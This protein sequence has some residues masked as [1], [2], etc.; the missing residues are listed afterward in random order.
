MAENVICPICKSEAEAINVGS[1]DGVGIRCKTHG[2]FEV[3]D[4][5][6]AMHKDTE[7]TR[8]EA[9]LG[10]AKEE[11]RLLRRLG[12]GLPPTIL[13]ECG[14]MRLL[15]LNGDFAGV[16][17][18]PASRRQIN[19]SLEARPFCRGYPPR[20]GSGAGHQ[21]RPRDEL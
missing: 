4:S 10:N 9:A 1:F 7:G 21:R 18:K 16:Y 20:L 13:D 8:W 12:H 6:L 17:D 19:I 15:V 5:A 11:R 3:A 14:R 2:E